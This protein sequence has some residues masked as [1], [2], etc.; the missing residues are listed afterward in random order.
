MNGHHFNKIQYNFF[1]KHLKADLGN[2]KMAKSCQWLVDAHR[3]GRIVNGYWLYTEKDRAAIIQ[4][5]KS[6]LNVDLL[7]DAYPEQQSRIEVAAYHNDEKANALAVSKDFVLVNS[8]N[9]L[10][11]NSKSLDINAFSSLGIY[12]NANK[13]ETIEHK[14]IVLVENLAVMANLNK[15]V[16][17]DNAKHL[18][19]ALWVYR[20][21]VKREQSTGRAYDFFRRFKGSHQL[22]CFADVDPEGIKIAITSGA[23]AILSPNAHA[24]INFNVGGHDFDYFKQSTAKQYL[25]NKSN[26]GDFPLELDKLFTAMSAQRQTIKQEHILAHQIPLSVFTLD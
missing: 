15:L 4:L 3:I 12:I 1:A 2:V 10:H 6:Q 14:H 13:I 25:M 26:Q 20:G 5:V 9:T 21:D 17:M 8:L 24:L 23:S 11:I 7:F 18:V 22:L 16:L 19:N